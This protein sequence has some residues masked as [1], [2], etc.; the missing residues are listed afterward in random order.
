MIP[1]NMPI[2]PATKV[3]I[4]VILGLAVLSVGL[5]VRLYPLFHYTQDDSS[6][7]AA[8]FV[9][10]QLRTLIRQKV[11]SAH[12]NMPDNLR[13]IIVKNE[14]DAILKNEGSKAKETIDRVSKDI[15]NSQ[16]SSIRKPYLLASDSYYYYGLTENILKNGKLGKETKGSKYLNKLMLAPY[17]HWEPITLHPYLGYCIYKIQKLF[18]PTVNLVY[19]VSFTPLLIAALSLIAFII[20]GHLMGFQT[21]TI[22]VSSVFFILAPIFVKRSMFGWYDNDP[23]SILFSLLIILSIITGVKNSR[24]VKTTILSSAVTALLFILYTLFWQGWVLM[25]SIFFV[26]GIL[27][28]LYQFVIKDKTK[29][30]HTL[31]FYLTASVMS[32]LSVSLVF[33]FKEFF[34][35]FNEGWVALKNF[36]EPQLSVWPDIYLT[37]SELKKSSFN[38]IV[39]MTGGWIFILIA[40]L[41]L[42]NHIF[43]LLLRKKD[44]DYTSSFILIT[45]LCASLYISLGAQRFVLFCVIP[46]SFFFA[47]GIQ[48]ILDKLAKIKVPNLKINLGLKYAA[49]IA[50]CAFTIVPIRSI[51][52]SV[53]KLLNPIYN[54][55]WEKALVYLRDNTD[56]DS[57]INTWWPPGHF[58]KT[59]AKRAVTFDGATINV[60]QA[61]W[62]SNFF[63]SQDE[64]AAIGILRML[65]N[66][67]NDSVEYL[68]KLGF[69]LPTSINMIKDITKRPKEEARALLSK[70]FKN[71]YQV[72]HLLELTHNT[73][74]SSYC[75]LYNEF[76]ENN[77]QLSFIGHWNFK[78]IT[79]I[80]NDP[81]KLKNIPKANSRA[82]IDYLWKLAGGSYKYSGPLA[83]IS[84]EGDII[85]FQDNVKIDLKTMQALIGS[86]K[87]GKGI[88]YSIFY[89]NNNEY[90]EKVSPAS[91]LPYSIALIK[92][93][94]G[95]YNAI[96]LDRPLAQS[97]IIRLYF[98][99]AVG[100]K[101]FKTV[102]EDSD[103][104]G[105][106][107]IKTFKA[108]F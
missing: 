50:A 74:P 30:R 29:L 44:F 87:F 83:Q 85:Y 14:L 2:K 54:S 5:H 13:E 35:L 67:G 73:P 71:S 104:T 89:I 40:L 56:E 53:D 76:V 21:I 37:V 45:F 12:P 32:F 70:A 80:N 10:N 38:Y 77:V 28:V 1:K 68:Q 90:T 11:Q 25:F 47:A 15:E 46:L 69:D 72:E 51:Y 107:V 81:Q 49:L 106:T 79:N 65:N 108:E 6:E 57:I 102:F 17:G 48:Y 24:N 31:F 101:H 75:L 23:Y 18:N 99:K 58:I 3:L 105:R 60:P 55:T 26:S 96:L 78:E 100:L 92:S 91:N 7:K 94:E 103:L 59:V 34:V 22:F 82:Y 97:M 95:R 20:T 64:N 63:L 52:G 33:G 16:N 39:E 86:K 93:P 19:A 43:K 42:W 61:Y 98:F 27:T 88:P 66:S 36:I 41:G 84:Q 9:I 4:S 8:V 62:L